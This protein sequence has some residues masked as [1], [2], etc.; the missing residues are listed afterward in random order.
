MSD[1]LDFS[2]VQT[3]PLDTRPSKVTLSEGAT[4]WTRGGTL[5]SF[6]S[7]LPGVL[8]AKDLKEIVQ[9]IAA[10]EGSAAV[11]EITNP[12]GDDPA[13]DLVTMIEFLANII[14]RFHG[15]KFIRLY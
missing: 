15:L 8:G 11:W 9:A 2:K 14:Q 13:N 4:P 10:V 7:G 3:V 5:Q 6:L 12:F 1:L